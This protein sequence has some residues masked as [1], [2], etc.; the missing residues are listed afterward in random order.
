MFDID[1]DIELLAVIQA[2]HA[3]RAAEQNGTPRLW[4]GKELHD[5]GMKLDDAL[6]AVVSR[7]GE[8]ILSY[9]P[10]EVAP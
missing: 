2:A 10:D 7:Y 9:D 8:E 4:R 6:E 3:Y 1:Q 5:L